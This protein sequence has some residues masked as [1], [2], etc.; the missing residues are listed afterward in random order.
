MTS[1]HFDD[2]QLQQHC[3]RVISLMTSLPEDLRPICALLDAWYWYKVAE[4][5]QSSKVS[6]AMRLLSKPEM[7]SALKS[8]Y[9]QQHNVNVAVDEFR[10]ILEK[11]TG[12]ALPLASDV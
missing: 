6:E 9:L 10:R 2:V 7:R 5:D 3:E 4:G 1:L 11:T 12:D 8:W